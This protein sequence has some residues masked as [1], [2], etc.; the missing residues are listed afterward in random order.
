MVE[1]HPL[2]SRNFDG[3]CTHFDW[4]YFGLSNDGRCLYS[5][6]QVAVDFPKF[7]GLSGVVTRT[8]NRGE[9]PCLVASRKIPNVER[10]VWLSERDEY[11]P[12]YFHD[13]YEAGG[14]PE[15]RTT[16]INWQRIPGGHLYPKSV[17]H[18]TMIM[19]A[20]GKFASEEVVIMT[21]ADFDSPIDPAVFTVAGLGLNENQVVGLPG[22]NPI[23][24]P[25]W[26]GG[27]LDPSYTAGSLMAERAKQSGGDA[28][29]AGGPPAPADYPSQGNTARV[30]GI[31]AAVLAVV[32]AVLAVVVRRKRA[33]A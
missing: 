2:G 22:L 14:M 1:F 30:V 20:A 10:S 8:E 16:E 5:R 13:W 19:L 24:H 21:H 17:K 9:P 7:F 26:R 11:N 25:V 31:V 4:R 3:Y 32:T 12:V 33:S 18:N 6:L 28:R 23:D 27:R 29:P 15:T